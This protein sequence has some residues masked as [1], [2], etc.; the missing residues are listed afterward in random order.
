MPPH[1]DTR[2]G[3]VALAV[4][5]AL[6]SEDVNHILIWMSKE[7]EKEMIEVFQKALEARKSGEAARI[8]ADE[9]VL[10]T[11]VRLHRATEGASF[12]GIKPAGLDEGPLV[13]RAEKA[14][15]TGDPTETINFLTDTMQEELMRRFNNVNNKKNY[16]V[17][18]VEAG[19]EYIEAFI[20]FVVFSHHL[21]LHISA[22]R[23]GH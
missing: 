12:T 9:W 1:C 2:D 6:D 14:I 13:P 23:H 5:K 16:D 3:P 15:E 19:R 4:K 22:D 8:V 20:G 10:E 7:S 11:A 21:Y 17:N 18:D